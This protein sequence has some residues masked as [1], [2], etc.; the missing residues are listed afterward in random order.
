MDFGFSQQEKAFRQEVIEFIHQ[1]FPPE[2]RW[3]FG[4][5]FTPSVQ[6][7][8]GEDWEYIKILRRKVGAKGWLSLSWPE[9][10]GGKN[11]LILQN[12]VFGIIRLRWGFQL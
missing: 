9:E 1:E 10:Y 4:C 11:S 12:I 3:K 2:L 7:H 8:E 6:S 5:T